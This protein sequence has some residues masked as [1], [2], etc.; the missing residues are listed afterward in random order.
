MSKSI[1]LFLLAALA[2]PA[3][4]QGGAFSN[5]EL[6]Q[7]LLSQADVLQEL[8]QRGNTVG[9]VSR[10]VVDGKVTYRLR[11]AYCKAPRCVDGATLTI[12]DTGVANGMTGVHVYR[13]SIETP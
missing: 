8:S 5:K 13:S 9:E 10:N 11:V 4:A 7:V 3:V 1:N 12:I 6:A 2:A